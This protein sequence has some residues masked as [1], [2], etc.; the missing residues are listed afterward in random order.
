MKVTMERLTVQVFCVDTT[1]AQ[2]NRFFSK[3][4]I[5]ISIIFK[6]KILL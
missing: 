6:T 5:K 1:Y 4:N 2:V 3:I